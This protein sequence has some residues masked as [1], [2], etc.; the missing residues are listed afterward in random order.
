MP[1]LMLRR[2]LGSTRAAASRVRIAVALTDDAVGRIKQVAA[3]CRALGF[4]H[5][6][7]LASV[8]VLTGAADAGQMARLRTVP[9]VLAVEAERARSRQATP[10]GA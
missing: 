9:G 6:T 10:R 7:T 1:G 4:E 3:A 5:H 2:R 8:G